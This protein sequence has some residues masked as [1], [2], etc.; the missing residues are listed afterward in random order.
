MKTEYEKCMNR[1]TFKGK[2]NK[3]T[4]ITLKTKRLLVKLN[5]N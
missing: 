5:T 3:L 4:E 2:D 1:E